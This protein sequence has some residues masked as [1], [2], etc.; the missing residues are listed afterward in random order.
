M[1][2]ERARE[3]RPARE[4]PQRRPREVREP[5][6]RRRASHSLESVLS[7][8]VALLDASGEPALTFR[9]LAARLGGGVGSIYWY[10]SSKD[11]LLDRAADHVMHDVLTAVEGVGSGD[12][13]DD[14]RTIAVTLFDAI[15]ERPWLGAYVMRDT[16]VQPNALLLYE[17]LG[18]QVLRLGLTPRQCFHAASAVVGFVVGIAADRGQEPPAAVLSGEVAREEY[19]AA[20][21]A[22]WQALDPEQYPFL[23]HIVDEFAVHDDADQFR[24]GLD[25]LLAGLRLQASGREA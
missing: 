24:A 17:K 18:Q 2:K 20:A 16:G 4:R 11:E 19:Q 15:V 12:P 1:P 3:P 6:G 9:A 7:E 5:R 13:L 8:A 25:L 21:V 14:V 10:V 23:H 22:Q